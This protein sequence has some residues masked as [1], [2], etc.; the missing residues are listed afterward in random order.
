M[1]SNTD[2]NILYHRKDILWVEWIE[3]Q[4]N[5]RGYSVSK[6]DFSKGKI[7]SIVPWLFENSSSSTAAILV[8]SEEMFTS[9]IEEEFQEALNSYGQQQIATYRRKSLKAPQLKVTIAASFIG[10]N[11]YSGGEAI[12]DFF[13]IMSFRNIDREE[14]DNKDETQAV[15]YP[16]ELPRNWKMPYSELN[17]FVGRNNAILDIEKKLFSA[18]AFN[19][20]PRVSGR[21]FGL[22]STL[23]KIIYNNISKF[24]TIW[25]LSAFDES[26]LIDGLKELGQRYGLQ[27]MSGGFADMFPNIWKAMQNKSKLPFL[28]VLERPGHRVMQDFEKISAAPWKGGAVVVLDGNQ[29]KDT[30]EEVQVEMMDRDDVNELIT[31]IVPSENVGQLEDIASFLKYHPL[32]VT[33]AAGLIKNGRKSDTFVDDFL[34][35]G[36]IVNIDKAYL[37]PFAILTRFLIDQL[38]FSNPDIEKLL[39]FASYFAPLPLP[40]CIFEPP[41]NQHIDNDMFSQII[42][43]PTRLNAGLNKLAEYGLINKSGSTLVMHPLIS[44]CITSMSEYRKDWPERITKMLSEKLSSD[45][46]ADLLEER[47]SQ[48]YPHMVD[49]CTNTIRSGNVT[50]E[51]SALINNVANQARALQNWSL[52]T[53]LLVGL[54][55]HFIATHGESNANV[56]NISSSLGVIYKLQNNILDA[57]Q[58]FEKALEIDREI[59]GN[60]NSV[61]GEDYCQLARIY[62]I[63]NK[64]PEAVDL[65]KKGADIIRSAVGEEDQKYAKLL[66][67]LIGAMKKNNQTSEIYDYAKTVVEI[68]QKIYGAESPKLVHSMVNVGFSAA[69]RQKY[70]EALEYFNKAMEIENKV[71]GPSH[72]RAGKMLVL[73]GNVYEQLGDRDNAKSKYELAMPIFNASLSGDHPSLLAVKERLARVS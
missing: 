23:T 49:I 22:T 52:A 37:K 69:S 16:G 63:E 21:G 11:E 45:L 72:I 35:E 57:K 31:T 68:E 62:E 61:V 27:G 5:S 54:Q 17:L 12:K 53:E 70:Q 58:M 18:H 13:T 7:K 29:K 6:T 10:E 32:L 71:Y 3:S 56:A 38:S 44:E 26:Q 55:K 50:D 33:I 20:K 2:I 41:D 40:P 4:C 25:W 30:V 8:E 36:Q 42:Y 67:E 15:I 66:G 47:R 14:L 59:Y 19:I 9:N 73:I 65:Y 64:I 39:S 34:L 46:P 43:N 51:V 48:I 24:S 28:I 60:S 1:K